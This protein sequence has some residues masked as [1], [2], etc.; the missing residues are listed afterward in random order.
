LKARIRNGGSLLFLKGVFMKWSPV[1][2]IVVVPVLSIMITGVACRSAEGTARRDV[3]V[4]DEAGLRGTPTPAGEAHDQHAPV[5]SS[6]DKAATGAG[7]NQAMPGMDHSAMG[8]AQSAPAPVTGVDHSAMGHGAAP[9]TAAPRPEPKTATATA[10][11]PKSTLRPDALDRAAPSAMEDASRAAAMSA[12]M[13]DGAHGTRHGTYIQKDAGLT[14]A[15]PQEPKIS[16]DADPHRMHR[17]PTP[18]KAPM[19]TPAPLRTQSPTPS[20]GTDHEGHQHAAPQVKPSPTPTP[21]PSARLE[22][23]FQ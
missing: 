21:T 6:K 7:G 22:E 13:A 4:H 3:A 23:A 12:G 9:P 18:G 5:S 1:G 15:T 2:L 8:H 11:Q 10:Q 19:P 14:S 16:P 17:A 20:P